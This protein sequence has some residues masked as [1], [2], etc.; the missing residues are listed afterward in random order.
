M[1][2]AIESIFQRAVRLQLDR[3]LAEQ[4]NTLE[5]F[6]LGG[7]MLYPNHRQDISI[8]VQYNGFRQKWWVR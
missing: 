7:A 5:R 3:E 4:E 8:C 1:T 2:A 6:A